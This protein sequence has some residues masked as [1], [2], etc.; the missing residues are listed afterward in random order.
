MTPLV[1]RGEEL[2]LIL[3]RWRL[4]EGRAGQIVLIFGEP[5]IGKSRL[6]LALRD[7]LQAE[8]ITLVSYACSPQHLNSPLFPFISQLER[9]A[10]FAPDDPSE[11]RLKRLESLLCENG[12]ELSDD[13]VP[14]FADLL[15]IQSATP[16]ALPDMSPQQ[17]KALLFRTFL[18]PARST[19][20]AWPCPDGA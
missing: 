17:R 14:L 8:P 15:G 2:D 16:H 18:G 20:G 13:A 6:V 9:E 5:G 3:S 19:C 7:R 12:D 4:A 10:R 1:G 11:E